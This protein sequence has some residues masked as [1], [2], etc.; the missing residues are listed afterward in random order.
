MIVQLFSRFVLISLLA[1]GG[2]G[3]ALPLVERLAVSETGWLSSQDF[4]VAVACGYVTPGPVLITATFVGYRAAGLSGAVAATFGVFLMPWLLAAAA[5]Q[6]LQRF[7]QHP[8]LA[9]FGRGAAPA[10]IGL[11]GV[12]ALNLAQQSFTHWA[13]ALL[14]IGAFGLA[15]WTK[16]HPVLLLI[17]GTVLGW[18]IGVFTAPSMP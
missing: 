8:R 5:A 13:Y 2:G 12:M 7:M 11:F 16:V 4:A 15:L 3:A 18:V 6:Q 10:V 1:F 14:A 9:G 17:G